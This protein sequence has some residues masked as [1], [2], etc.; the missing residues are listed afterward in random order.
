LDNTPSS[1]V[2]TISSTVVSPPNTPLSPDHPH[3]ATSLKKSHKKKVPEVTQT[4]HL[5]LSSEEEPSLYITADA[6]HKSMNSKPFS[7]WKLQNYL[8][9]N[10]KLK[11]ITALP[12]FFIDSNPVPD[13][14]RLVYFHL[15]FNFVKAAFYHLPGMLF[16]ADQLYNFFLAFC[17]EEDMIGALHLELLSYIYNNVKRNGINY[18]YFKYTFVPPA[19]SLCSSDLISALSSPPL[20]PS[21]FLTTDN[22]SLI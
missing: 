15:L 6:F 21:S 4:C 3:A 16:N 17:Q 9:K 5:D 1:Q 22:M 18:F 8:Q 14:L 11:P 19:P 12:I 13:R 10:R 7:H 20:L 2:Y